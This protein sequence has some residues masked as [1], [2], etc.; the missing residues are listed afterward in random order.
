M[1]NAM[2]KVLATGAIRALGKGD[3]KLAAEAISAMSPKGRGVVY[4]VIAEHV[5]KKGG[6]R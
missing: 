1:G 4:D 5:A 6:K 3:S 2:D